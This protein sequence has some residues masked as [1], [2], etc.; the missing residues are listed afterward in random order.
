MTPATSLTRR[1]TPWCPL[2][3]LLVLLTSCID[4]FEADLP[5]VATHQ[6]V[7]EGSISAQTVSTFTLTHTLPFSAGQSSI[8]DCMIADATVR[9]MGDDGQTWIA[10]M[11][12]P[13]QYEVPVGALSPE[14]HYWLEVEWEGQRYASSPLLPLAT[15]DI[16]SLRYEQPRPDR[17]IDILI[18]SAPDDDA[19]YFRWE[20]DEH[21][22]I[23]TPMSTVFAY[24]PES[25]SIAY[26]GLITHRGWCRQTTHRAIIA[27]CSGYAG[28][29][30][31]DHRI[32]QLP[33]DDDRFNTRYYTDVTQRAI[34]REE[35]EYHHLSLQLSDEMGGLFTPQPSVLPS[36][37]RC[38]TAQLPCIGFVGVSLNV[39]HHRLCINRADVG[40]KFTTPLT[41]LPLAEARRYSWRQLYEMGYRIITYRDLPERFIQWGPRWYVDCTDRRWGASLIQPDGYDF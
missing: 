11:R 6:L 28:Q 24:L 1:P 19:T 32:Y 30:L 7:I 34:T 10:T 18:S 5:D 39:S 41:P 14:A 38:L 2:W 40:Y 4:P 31:R 16:I 15:P 25:D 21:W 23:R 20:Y 37:V 27:D 12:N 8:A 17:M 26:T 13:G 9:V 35:Y 36:N 33:N 3:A 22:E 29:Q